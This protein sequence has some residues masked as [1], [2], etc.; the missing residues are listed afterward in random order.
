[1]FNCVKYIKFKCCKKKEL[2]YSNSINKFSLLVIDGVTNNFQ[3]TPRGGIVKMYSRWGRWTPGLNFTF[4]E[5]V[6][7]LRAWTARR[8][9][10]LGGDGSRGNTRG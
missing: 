1:M 6:Q 8:C 4:Q 2:D 10:Q 9:C 7:V 3:N 5:T